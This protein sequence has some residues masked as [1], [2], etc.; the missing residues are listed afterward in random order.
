[1]S[2][3]LPWQETLSR[4]SD[5]GTVFAVRETM[6]KEPIEKTDHQPTFVAIPHREP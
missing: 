2:G 3:M 5:A 1:M 6:Q 4:G